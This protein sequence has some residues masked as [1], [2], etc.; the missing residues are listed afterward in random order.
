MDPWGIDVLITASQKGLMTPPGLG[1]CIISENV[2]ENINNYKP[3]NKMISPY[4]DCS[5]T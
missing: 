4:W 2:K 3:S 5:L 1:Y